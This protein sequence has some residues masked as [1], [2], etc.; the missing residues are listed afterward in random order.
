MFLLE[1]RP[2]VAFLVQSGFQVNSQVVSGLCLVLVKPA[3]T[4][5]VWF[6][7]TR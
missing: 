6:T 4:S 2:R 5:V 1:D 7:L 3:V